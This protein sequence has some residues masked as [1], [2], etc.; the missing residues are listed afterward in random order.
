MQNSKLLLYIQNFMNS[1]LC[2]K[3]NLSLIININK[4][5]SLHYHDQMGKEIKFLN[6]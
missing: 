2:T 4:S 3:Q 6:H 1:E 5:K